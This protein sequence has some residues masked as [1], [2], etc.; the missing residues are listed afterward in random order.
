MPG[1]GNGALGGAEPGGVG[2]AE[3][4][5]WASGRLAGKR[6]SAKV[7]RSILWVIWGMD[8][9]AHPCGLYSLSIRSVRALIVLPTYDEAA[10]IARMLEAIRSVL[11]DGEVLVVDDSSPDGTAEIAE[12]IAGRLGGIHVLRRSAKSGLGSAYRDGFS[13]GLERG[14]DALVEMDADFS[15]DPGQLPLLLAPIQEGRAEL[16]IGSRYVQGG[17]IPNWSIPRLALSRSGNAYSKAL[18]SLGVSDMTSGFRAYAASL[19]TRLPMGEVRA[20]G[21]GFQIEMVYFAAKDGA[22]IVET[23]IRFVDRAEGYSKMSGRTIVE[24]LALV[25]WWGLRD[26]LRGLR[27]KR[28][29]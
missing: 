19:L 6:L 26:R 7:E 4:A 1:W 8:P 9:A 11:P 27:P 16:V 12:V 17:S 10:N 3:E 24:A 21:Y 22:K 5:F 25:T 23:P 15:H 29:G 18:L 14:F 20:D 2:E 28:A 13:W